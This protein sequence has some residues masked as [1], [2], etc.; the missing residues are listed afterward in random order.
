MW[1]I[2]EGDTKLL[3]TM[4]L[5][6]PKDL[7]SICSSQH[8]SLKHYSL[9]VQ[10]LFILAPFTDKHGFAHLKKT[11]HQSTSTLEDVLIFMKCI[12]NKHVLTNLL[13]LCNIPVL[14]LGNIVF[15]TGRSTT[16]T[17]RDNQCSWMSICIFKLDVKNT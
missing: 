4:K 16:R 11:I 12:L 7:G 14:R 13:S 10:A 15:V 6:S 5:M 3:Y 2:I 1:E 9:K 8:Y 17:N